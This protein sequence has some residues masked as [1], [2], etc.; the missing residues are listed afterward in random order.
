MEKNRTIIAVSAGQTLYKKQVNIIRKRIK[1]LNYGLLGL[2]TLVNENLPVNIKMFQA[3]DLTPENLIQL[4]ENSGISF[5]E[6][7]EILLSIPSFYSILWCKQFCSAVKSISHAKIIAGGRWV[8]DGNITWLNEKI[9]NIDIFIEGFGE[10]KI[11]EL[12]GGNACNISDGAT[13]CFEKLDYRLLYNYKEY[14]PCIEVSRGCGA[15]CNFCADRTNRRL[16]NKKVSTITTELNAIDALYPQYTYYMEA[17]HFHFASNWVHSLYEEIN[18]RETLHYWRCTSRVESVPLDLLQELSQTGLKVI[19]IGLESAS[20]TQLMRMG[21]TMSPEMYLTQAEKILET[22]NKYEIWV[23]FNLLLYP[24]ETYK[25]INETMSWLNSHKSLI[26]NVSVSSLIYY[27]NMGNLNSLIQ[28]GARIS[29]AELLDELGYLNLDLSDEISY[30]TA[31]KYALT[32]PRLVSNQKD[33][34]DIKSISYFSPSYSYHNFLDDLKQCNLSEL[35]FKY[36]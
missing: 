12:L 7:S 32:I 1:Y 24:G 8:V 4:I 31:Q 25:T 27:R 28:N 11:V 19:D 15:G 5:N 16:P 35:P 9:G 29:H 2:T 14:Q 30:D 10:K 3:N 34:Y 18:R 36:L 33:F 21:K 20:P 13:H 6:C 17:P 26:K 22:C 23:K